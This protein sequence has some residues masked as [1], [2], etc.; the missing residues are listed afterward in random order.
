MCASFMFMSSRLALRLLSGTLLATALLDVPVAVSPETGQV[1]GVF[2]LVGVLASLARLALRRRARSGA[3][4][5]GSD[6]ERRDGPLVAQ[7]QDDKTAGVRALAGNTLRLAG[8]RR[9]KVP[10]AD[11]LSETARIMTPSAGLRPSAGIG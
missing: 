8:S 9:P 7:M 5:Q 3:M 4:G 2:A 6:P 11:N 10:Y 1:I